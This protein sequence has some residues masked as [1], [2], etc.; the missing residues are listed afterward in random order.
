M[1]AGNH[2]RNHSLVCARGRRALGL[3]QPLAQSVTDG[4][5]CLK[6]LCLQTAAMSLGGTLL[7][8]LCQNLMWL[9]GHSK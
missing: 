8:P 9:K 4:L 3:A 2:V 1:A 7:M 5:L 6:V